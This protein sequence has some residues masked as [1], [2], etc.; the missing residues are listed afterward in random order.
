MDEKKVR[1][2]DIAKATNLSKGAVSFALRG[3]PMVSKKTRD[4]VIETAKKMGYVRNELF[5]S[6]M[7]KMKKGNLA[8]FSESIALI[9]ANPDERMLSKHPTLIKY[10]AGIKSEAR[11]LGYLLNEIWLYDSR[12]KGKKLSRM[13][14]SRG[15][16]GGIVM[17]HFGGISSE[18]DSLWKEFF[19]ISMGVKTNVSPLEMVS[20]DHYSVTFQAVMNLLKLGYKRPS[21][22]L[23][24]S[25][26]DHVDGRFVAGFMRAQLK[27][28]QSDRIAPFMELQKSP[29]YLKNLRA[30]IDANKPDAILYLTDFVR[31]KI[32][33]MY[34]KGSLK[35]TLVQLERRQNIS[36]W[37][38]ME[39]NNETVGKV[40]M[41][42]LA[43]M[44]SRDSARIGENAKMVTSVPPTWM[45]FGFAK[46]KSNRKKRES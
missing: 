34:K 29:T 5:S 45:E 6:M 28:P 40:A 39:Q 44:L 20:V 7:S 26:D 23:E 46:R 43:D 42:R 27:I 31:E 30:W 3:S 19:F 4:R 33:K 11:R 38:G 2:S 15:I 36:N 41:R 14:T 22:V 37:I 16:R 12:L 21:L 8:S 25:T 13:L 24:E 32:L 17:G 9:N 10:C 1:L 18:Y 35:A